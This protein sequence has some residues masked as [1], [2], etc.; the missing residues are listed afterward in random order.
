M[1]VCVWQRCSG[2][3]TVAPV[4]SLVSL[5]STR[6]LRESTSTSS[7][8]VVAALSA[9]LL[10]SS[11]L[12]PALL[13]LASSS[14]GGPSRPELRWRWWWWPRAPPSTSASS[15]MAAASATAS[16]SAAATCT[17]PRRARPPRA[18][19]VSSSLMVPRPGLALPPSAGPSPI[20]WLD[21][22]LT[23]RATNSDDCAFLMAVAPSSSSSSTFMSLP[24]SSGSSMPAA[25]SATA[26]SVL[27]LSPNPSAAWLLA[28]S[29]LES[30]ERE[31]TA[32]EPAPFLAFSSPSATSTLARAPANA[33][34]GRTVASTLVRAPKPSETGTPC[35][36]RRIVP[37][38]GWAPSK[39][40]AGDSVPRMLFFRPPAAFFT[41]ISSSQSVP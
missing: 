16:W 35:R 34:S 22:I 26:R 20:S 18:L 28:S 33:V 23:Q 1:Y 7:R 14:P 36:I 17:E 12:S 38:S 11:S 10:W 21:T 9:A 3:M 31:E 29:S 30:A 27:A 5:R 6:P 4:S 15:G 8:W 13:S 41:P 37:P 25:S 39:P 40:T 24:S 2:T 19:P 32:L